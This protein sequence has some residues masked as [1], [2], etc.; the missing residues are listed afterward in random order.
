MDGSLSV[1]LVPWDVIGSSVGVS[2]LREAV[3][4]VMAASPEAV[5]KYNSYML[6]KR[7][8]DEFKKLPM[9]EKMIAAY[10]MQLQPGEGSTVH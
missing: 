3:V 4:S 10:M 9:R 6:R 1:T 2:I 5:V 7:R 8:E